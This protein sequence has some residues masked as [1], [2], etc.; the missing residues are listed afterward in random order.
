MVADLGEAIRRNMYCTGWFFDWSA[1]KYDS[2][3]S[4]LHVSP[5]KKVLS[6]RIS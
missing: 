3:V 1:L 2:Y 6:V 4:R 5:F